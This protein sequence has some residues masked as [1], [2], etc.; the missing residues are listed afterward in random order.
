MTDS[1][2]IAVLICAAAAFVDA[3]CAAV[4]FLRYKRTK[5]LWLK[6]SSLHHHLKNRKYGEYAIIA[7]FA[8]ITLIADAAAVWYAVYLHNT[9]Q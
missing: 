3:I 5:K 1:L 4:Q 9:Y 6:G 8:V 7:V 2:H